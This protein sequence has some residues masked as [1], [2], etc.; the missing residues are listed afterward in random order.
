MHSRFSPTLIVSLSVAFFGS[1]VSVARADLVGW[2]PLDVN[3]REGTGKGLN[4][5]AIGTP[6]FVEPR[7][8]L[9][10]QALRLPAGDAQGVH[11][12]PDPALNADV[13]TLGYFINLDGVT[14]G[15]AGLERLT[16]REGD[17]FET[18]VGDAHAVGGNASET[19]IT[20]TYYQGSWNVTQVPIPASGWVHVAWQN[21][22]T[23][24]TLYI[25]GVPLYVGPAVPAGRITGLM[26]IG[27]RHN[28]SEGFEG[29]IDDVFLWNDAV[30]PLTAD[31]I[32]DISANGL[33]VHLGLTVDSDGDGL[34]DG[35]EREHNLNPLDNGSVN[36]NNGANG[37]PDADGVT[38]LDEFTGGTDPQDA[39]TDHDGLKDGAEAAA[40]GDPTKA[41]T[42]G[43]GLNDG[44]EITAGTKV[45]EPDTDGDGIQ[46]GFEVR[47]G[48]DPLDP[49]SV[50]GVSAFLV[51]RLGFDDSVADLSGRN[52]NGT[53]VGGAGYS[54]NV[55][56][57]L[58]AGK[59]L[60]LTGLD[61]DGVSVNADPDLNANTFTL[62]YWLNA[63]NASQGN[64]GLE[65]LTSRGGD[66]FETAIGDAHA[67][68]GT[69]SSTGVTLSYYQ[70]QWHVTQVEIPVEG[71]VH[72]V[73]RNRAD[74]MDLF[75]N[76]QLAYTGPS[77][78]AGKPSGVMSIGIRYNNLEGFEG[79]MDEVLLYAT[80][81]S[82][83]EI[84]N[85]AQ[86]ISILP[87]RISQIQRNAQTRAVSITWDSQP[88]L[89]YTIEYSA[90]LKTWT[91]LNGNQAS[92]GASTTFTDTTPGANDTVR[93]YR[94]RQN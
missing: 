6:T 91:V 38:N 84:S 82:D 87:L 57:I 89:V 88:A 16:S 36:P 86:G 32:A 22:A 48:S 47:N 50:P 78:P 39:D 4:G 17:T 80:A 5:T 3:F 24:M 43:D 34:P 75:I 44:A 23:E 70:G 61:T 1:L 65:R 76:G 90:D 8:G 69:T 11:I 19:G 20:L 55:P 66:S 93:F 71:W 29:I 21:T 51:L 2:W 85:L 68:G 30:N 12:D 7:L 41:D 9:P 15:N 18:A 35:W 31:A 54:D 92:G 72:A 79:L 49:T 62:A 52:H 27:T 53:L 26:N 73:W 81:L 60:S 42:D 10:G 64:A 83:E 63:N 67:V 59:S 77:V 33:A 74:A 94:V 14:Q 37:D 13:F 28:T 25:D 45:N 40:G 56:A 46:D 58:G